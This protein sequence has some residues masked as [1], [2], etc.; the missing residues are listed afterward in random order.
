MMNNIEKVYENFVF[1]GR[2]SN[3]YFTISNIGN[4]L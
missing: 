4:L 2:F 3:S 1:N